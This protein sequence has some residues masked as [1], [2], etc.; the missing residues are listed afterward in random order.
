MNSRFILLPV[1]LAGGLGSIY[2]LPKAGD[3][4]AAAVNME[5]PETVTEWMLQSIPPSEAE[6]GTLGPDTKFS[7]AICRAPRIG[8]FTIDG[9]RIPDE[10]HL[11]IVL[12]GYDL[13]TSIHRPERCM[14]AQGH[15]DIS[16]KD[17][18]L[19]V[20]GEREFKVKRLTSTQR[21]KS[22]GSDGES[23]E[24]KCITYYFFVGHD[25]ITNDHL[26][27]TFIDMK[28]RVVRGMDQRWAYVSASMWYGKLPWIEAVVSEEEAEGKMQDFIRNF[29]AEQINWDQIRR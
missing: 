18:P 23:L 19:K 10:L 29:S 22:Q 1:I 17:V 7:K 4:A 5:L 14:P 25:R 8:E 21:L 13:N 27:R 2:F 28:D 16:S 12:S 26:E 3:V 24:M 15:T 11:S 6:I 9:L 20:A